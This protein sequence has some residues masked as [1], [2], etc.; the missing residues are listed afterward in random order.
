MCI[1]PYGEFLAE[2]CED[3]QAQVFSLSERNTALIRQVNI[4]RHQ[5]PDDRREYDEDYMDAMATE[6]WWYD[7]ERSLD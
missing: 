5:V 1:T 6:D 7:R 3:L 2:T 4:L